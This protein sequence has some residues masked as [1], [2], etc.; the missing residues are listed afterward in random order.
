MK[1]AA[2]LILMLMALTLFLTVGS[3]AAADDGDGQT[4]GG[5]ELFRSLPAAFCVVADE[6]NGPDNDSCE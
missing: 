4:I 6:D 1:T 3:T 5:C 2:Y